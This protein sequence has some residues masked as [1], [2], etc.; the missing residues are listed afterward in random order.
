MPGP[1]LLTIVLNYRTP[2]LTLQA[3]AAALRETEGIEGQITVVDNASQDGSFEAI[4][5]AVAAAGW[6]R[7]GRVR[8]IRSEKNGG[9]GAGNNV[10]IRAGL[11]S[12]GAPDYVYI[13]NS[14]AFPDAGA[15]R[16]LVDCL[17]ADP[18]VGFAG[19]YIHGPDG[20]PHESAFRF[21]SIWSELE[22]SMRTGPMT[23]LLARHVVALP[24]PPETRDVG[25]LA[26]ASVMMRRSLLDEIGLFDEGYFLYFDETDLCLRAHRAGARIVYVRESVVTH[27]GSV[28]TGMKT[29]ARIPK[30]W[31]DSRLRY[32]AKNHGRVYAG[33]ATLA[34]VAGGLAWRARRLVQRKPP[35]DPPFFLRDLVAHAARAALRPGIGPRRPP[36]GLPRLARREGR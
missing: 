35:A 32:F 18:A 27:V 11:A 33:A 24:I 21:P 26:G 7:A 9:Y 23:Q 3:V 10:G 36:A 31:L 29:W 12:G 25:W 5:D 13:L 16:A 1:T 17:E 8:V 19:S 20:V 15:V 28:S 4:S 34:H 22:G 14:D 6:D 2:D 30:Y